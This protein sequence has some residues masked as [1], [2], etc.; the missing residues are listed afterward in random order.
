MGEFLFGKEWNKLTGQERSNI[1]NGGYNKNTI[2]EYRRDQINTEFNKKSKELGY[3]EKYSE[4]D[5]EGQRRVRAGKA[6][7]LIQT[8][9]QQIR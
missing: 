2:T 6:T 8:G 5:Y 1:V 9:F 4:M 3:N 7:W